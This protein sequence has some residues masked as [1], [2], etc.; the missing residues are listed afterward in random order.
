MTKKIR[1]T[2][3]KFPDIKVDA[4]T[5]RESEHCLS[6]IYREVEILK[7]DGIPMKGIIV[8]LMLSSVKLA[9]FTGSFSP[10]AMRKMFDAV[11]DQYT[12]EVEEEE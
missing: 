6:S 7:A 3:D 5:L 2:P 12:E 11:M 10:T 9:S 8:S 4:A 1:Y